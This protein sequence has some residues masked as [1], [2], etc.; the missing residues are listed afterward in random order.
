MTDQFLHAINYI[1]FRTRAPVSPDD[2]WLDMQIALV[3]PG[4]V[5]RAG[6]GFCLD[7][8]SFQG[9]LAR[10]A[11]HFIS[12]GIFESNCMQNNTVSYSYIRTLV[13]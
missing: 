5:V 4:D 8:T 9:L 7:T 11:S 1:R 10:V 6:N 3:P 2:G 13:L 12:G